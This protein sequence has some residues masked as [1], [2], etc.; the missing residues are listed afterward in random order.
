MRHRAQTGW[1]IERAGGNRD[2]VAAFRHPKKT[3]AANRTETSARLRRGLIPFQAIAACQLEIRKRG[4]GVPGKMPVRS[5]ALAAMAIDDIAQ[6]SGHGVLD[7]TAQAAA[8]VS[9]AHGFRPIWQGIRSVTPNDNAVLVRRFGLLRTGRCSFRRRRR[10]RRGLVALGAASGVDGT[11]RA[12]LCRRWGS[13]GLTSGGR[14]RVRFGSLRGLGGSFGRSLA[15]IGCV[16]RER[17]RDRRPFGAE[18]VGCERGGL[19]AG[20]IG[21]P[22][23]AIAVV[24]GVDELRAAHRGR[25]LVAQDLFHLLAPDLAL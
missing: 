7:A 8:A 13:T 17:R 14:G 9:L 11:G 24:E 15:G 16:L 23:A 2:V 4:F 1:L 6:G 12:L 21:T 22:V 25:S 5:P 19:G 10:R 20:A 18:A 3:R